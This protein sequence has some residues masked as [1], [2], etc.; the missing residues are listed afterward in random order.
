MKSLSMEGLD[1]SAGKRFDTGGRLFRDR[2]T[3]ADYEEARRMIE[4]RAQ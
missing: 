4:A 2:N 1:E 3:R